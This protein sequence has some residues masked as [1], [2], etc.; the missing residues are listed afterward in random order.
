MGMLE[1]FIK[2]AKEEFGLTIT[3]ISSDNPD[4]FE[5]IF[6]EVYMKDREIRCKFYKYEGG[7]D[8]GKEGT[9]HHACQH[10]VFYVPLKGS[11]PA[12]KDN[13]RQKLERINRKER[14]E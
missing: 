3:P 14:F 10:C 1:D 5:K 12:R 11:A 7:C 13:R 9:F 6:G 4:T 8:M 2:Y